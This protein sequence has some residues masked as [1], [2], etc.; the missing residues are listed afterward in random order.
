[1]FQVKSHAKRENIIVKAYS[2]KKCSSY[3]VALPSLVLINSIP[4][5]IFLRNC[6]IPA[7]IL[8]SFGGVSQWR[9]KGEVTVEIDSKERNCCFR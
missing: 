8:L 3:F 6:K 4:L 5:G 2:F 9:E 1:M 7:K